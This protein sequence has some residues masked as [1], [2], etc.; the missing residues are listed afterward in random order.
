MKCD[1]CGKEIP[2]GKLHHVHIKG[3]AKKVCME[4]VTAVKG[5]A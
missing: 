4:C 5:L 2:E 1:L 3:D